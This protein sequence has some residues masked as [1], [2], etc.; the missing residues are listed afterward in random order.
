MGL[1]VEVN[2][3]MLGSL[4]GYT[5]G[6]SL[7][8]R[9]SASA[10]LNRTPS[11]TGNRQ[12]FTWSGWVKRGLLTTGTYYQLFGAGPTSG[13]NEGLFFDTTSG[14]LYFTPDA[15]TAIVTSSVYRDPSAWYHIVLSVDTTQATSANREIIYVNGVQVTSYT[16]TYCAQNTNF[17][18]INVASAQHRIGAHLSS[19]YYFDGYMA[20]VNFIDGQALTPSSFGAYDTNGVWQPKK[21]SGTYGTNGFYLPFTSGFNTTQTYA[22]GFNGSNQYLSLGANAAYSMGTGDFT[23]EANVNFNALPSASAIT[24][25]FGNET[26]TAAAANDKFWIGLYNS[27]GQYQLRFGRHNAPNGS[28]TVWTPNIGTWYHIAIVRQSGVISIY[29]NGVSQTM[30]QASDMAHSFGQ[31]GLT[32]GL[33]STPYYMNG[34]ISNARYVVGSAVYTA[35]FTPPSANLTAITNTKLLTLQNATIIDNSSLAATI[36]NTGS[37]V[38]TNQYPFQYTLASVGSDYSGNNNNWTLNNINYTILGTTYDSMIDS[39]TNS[40]SS[41]NY[42]VMNPL[43]SAIPLQFGNLRVISSAASTVGGGA[44]FAFPSGQ[45]YWEATVTLFSG[46]STNILLGITDAAK[47]SMITPSVSTPSSA[48]DFTYG[49]AYTASSGNIRKYAVDSAYGATFTTGDIIGVAYDATNN[50]ITFYKN[51]TSQGQ[52]TGLTAGTYIPWVYYGGSSATNTVD[53]NFGQRPF[54]YTP[55]SGYKALN[56]YNL[57]A[58][59]I[60]N[61]AQYMAAT[62]YTANGTT[63]SISNAVNGVSFQPDLVWQKRRN[64]AGS[65]YL[66]DSLRGT[67]KLLSSD[68]T[69]AEAT[70]TTFLTSF[71]SDGWSQG[72]GNYTNGE[73]IVGWQW[74]GGGTGV[75]NTSGTITS[76]V[77]AS[78]SSGFS[79]ATYTGT[80]AN[81]T[82]GHGLGVAP[83][84]V[85][86]KNRSSVQNW[87]TYHRSLGA[88]GNVYLNLT[89]GYSADSTTHNN[90]APTSSVF[91]VATS[92]AVNGS[93]NNIVAYCFSAVSGYSA[94]GKYTGNGSADGPFIYTGFRPRWVMIKNTQ[95]GTTN[96]YIY[97]TSRDT[98]NIMSNYLMSNLSNAEAS[99]SAM[100]Y[101]SNGFKIRTSNLNFNNSGQTHIYMAF[102]ES[103]FQISRAR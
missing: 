103:P 72:T 19:G 62:T 35:G 39:P 102:A 91:T 8:F 7:R 81:A 64:S 95:D 63:Q 44:T 24:A 92:G 30:V 57:P 50:T 40:A 21:Y 12:K 46:A 76:T 83:D 85:I 80:G 42:A 60:A 25:I 86:W 43:N 73:S 36:T 84:L 78:P 34:Y 33:V 58:P 69:A 89:A 5:V 1:P 96:W 3:L 59:S 56:T 66:A 82:V 53:M 47:S 49:Y 88:S 23:F 100:D 99:F 14:G 6:R 98:Y 93:T 79:I 4:G 55:P 15:S 94:F 51:G 27:A 11:S 45:W 67:S 26:N 54:S 2:N 31:N 70:N 32:L 16:G 90:T 65:H 38:T 74:K 87:V 41:S 13:G 101:L 68:T 18:Y 17:N 28:W 22:G 48:V 29:I 97:D 52:V 61:G 77:S 71:N 20:E 9:S 37:I 75:T 10:Y